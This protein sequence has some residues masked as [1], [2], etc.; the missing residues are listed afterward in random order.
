[1]SWRMFWFLWVHCIIHLFWSLSFFPVLCILQ[2][3]INIVLF[4]KQLCNFLSVRWDYERV[5][6]VTFELISQEYF[7]VLCDSSCELIPGQFKLNSFIFL[8]DLFHGKQ[9]LSDYFFT[10]H[11]HFSLNRFLLNIHALLF[12]FLHNTTVAKIHI[13]IFW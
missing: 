2:F 9:F 4:P 6:G 7:H 11:V 1:M 12:F 3:F 8:K 5:E 13:L 10:K